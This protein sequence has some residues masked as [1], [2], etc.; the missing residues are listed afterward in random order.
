MLGNKRAE[1]VFIVAVFV[2]ILAYYISFVAV[3]AKRNDIYFLYLHVPPAWVCY[4]AFTISLVSSIMFL[5]K[6]KRSYDVIAENAAIIG[7]LFG[8]IA[9]LIGSIW[10]KLAWGSFWNWDPRETA[11][12][13]LWLVYMGYV[14]LKLSIENAEKRATIGAVYNIFAFSTVP[15]SYLSVEFGFSQHQSASEV[16][17]QMSEVVKSALI[18]DLFAVTLLF[19]ALMLLIWEVKSLEERADMLSIA[20]SGGVRDDI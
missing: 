10:A 4:M 8:A 16:L 18:F 5:V 20:V 3:H 1:G 19:I 11:T 7:L 2:N 14:V 9:L 13:I 15:L 6:H 12:L 17:P